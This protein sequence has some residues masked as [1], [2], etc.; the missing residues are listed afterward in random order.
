MNFQEFNS[1]LAP[2]GLILAGI[3]I[4]LSNNNELFGSFKKRWYVFLIYRFSITDI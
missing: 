4:K 3:I 1:Y 2:V